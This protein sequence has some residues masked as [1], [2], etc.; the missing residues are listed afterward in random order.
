MR[1]RRVR[2]WFER[3][4]A[5]A[6]D[7]VVGLTLAAGFFVVLLWVLHRFIPESTDLGSF[8]GMQRDAQTRAAPTAT[9]AAP[10]STSEIA[11]LSVVR[12]DVQDKP[13]NSI[14]WFVA[15]KGGRL[16]NGHAVQSYANASARVD[17]DDRNVI[18]LGERTIVVLR[19]PER[20]SS[21]VPRAATVLFMDGFLR[22]RI[23]PSGKT[24]PAVDFQSGGASV[25]P[26]GEIA[27][28]VDKNRATLAVLEGAAE[29]RWHDQVRS[30]AAGTM[31][32][33]DAS[34][35]PGTPVP[36]PAPPSPVTPREG[37]TFLFRAN[38]PKVELTW[39]ASDDAKEFRVQIASDPQFAH[40]VYAGRVS[41]RRLVHGSLPSGSYVWRVAG[42]RDGIEGRP[43]ATLGF[44]VA[45]TQKAPELTVEF[46]DGVVT[47]ETLLL[48]G[49]TD[50]GCQIFV[51]DVRAATDPAG[52]FEQSVA[53]RPGYNFLVVQAVDAVGNTSFRNHTVMARLNVPGD[54]R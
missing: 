26:K 32:S 31:V 46:P 50:P 27:L 6:L 5:Y 39:T 37:E 41:E 1:P 8:A 19:T 23:D 30:I 54:K 42:V 48:R 33:Y 25:V 38:P 24:S 13:A 29:L 4:L 16:G 17:F 3:F 7:L 36:L 9:E 10:K 11:V 40:V 20:E 15:R 22:A 45:Q 44:V 49:S 53:L 43:S 34:H 12:G 35:A 14:A 2:P 47:A 51:N 18:E 52:R 21:S 28:K